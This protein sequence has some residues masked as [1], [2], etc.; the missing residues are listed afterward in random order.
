MPEIRVTYAIPAYL[1]HDCDRMHLDSYEMQE[2]ILP[3]HG[4]DKMRKAI[5]VVIRGRNFKAVAQPLVAFVGKAPLRYLRIA[6]DERSIEGILLEE[7]QRRA[8]VEVI[9]GDQ[10]GARHPTV[11]NPATIV[12]I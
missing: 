8:R 1:N 2:V 6:P 7:P 5:R 10:D 3:E 11:V 4:R 12:R 9:L